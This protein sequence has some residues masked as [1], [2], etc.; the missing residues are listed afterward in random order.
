MTSVLVQAT[1]IGGTPGDLL[2]LVRGGQAASRSDLARLTGLAPSTVSL[3][4][5][6]LLRL[7]LIREPVPNPR[8]GRKARKLE[9]NGDAGY[10]AS[11]DLGASHV[12]IALA[13]LRGA[14]LFDEPFPAALID[15]DIAATVGRLWDT[16]G[17]LIDS[18]Q[19]AP[20][21][22]LGITVGVPA[23]VSHRDG[24]I[25]SP[26][27]MPAWNNQSL[28]APFAQHTAV[29]VMVENDAIP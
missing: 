22:L 21:R 6:G 2:Q 4:V 5:D 17:T 23:P 18:L 24:R 12:R 7:G 15:E 20:D 9:I 29:P 1:P 19:L 27:F 14:V 25:V 16:V 13:D 3:K 28:S 8:G 26:A 10:V 11:I